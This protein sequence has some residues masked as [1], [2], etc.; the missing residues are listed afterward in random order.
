MQYTFQTPGL[1]GF[2]PVSLFRLEGGPGRRSIPHELRLGKEG[3]NA[4]VRV[5]AEI[6]G[7]TFAPYD[8]LNSCFI[9]NGG[10][11]VSFSPTKIV[12]ETSDYLNVTDW[13]IDVS[14]SKP[15][16]CVEIQFSVVQTGPNGLGVQDEPIIVGHVGGAETYSYVLTDPSKKL[17]ILAG[18][19][20]VSTLIGVTDADGTRYDNV[21]FSVEKR[22][23]HYFDSNSV[24][25]ESP[26]DLVYPIRLLVFT[27]RPG[28]QLFVE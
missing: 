21:E 11:E 25:V 19:D 22:T 1:Y 10:S 17:W 12:W 4:P 9:V 8:E 5:I 28:A 27:D 23:S 20:D 2:R 16:E 15:G 3:V 14:A 6:K 13:D 18:E 7:A 24:E 26:S